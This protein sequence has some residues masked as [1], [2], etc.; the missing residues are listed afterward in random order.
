MTHVLLVAAM[1]LPVSSDAAEG[2]AAPGQARSG[3]VDSP[4]DLARSVPI[5]PGQGPIAILDQL[6]LLEDSESVLTIDQVRQR[7]FPDHWQKN[8]SD[9]PNFGFTGHTYWF[10]L[11]AHSTKPQIINQ[12]L[13]I[14]YP[15]LDH[16][17]LWTFPQG[18]H[19]VTGDASAFAN[20]PIA[21]RTFLFPFE[22]GPQGSEVFIRV[23]TEGAAKI[24]I[25]LWDERTFF[26]E[27]ESAMLKYGLFLGAIAFV[28][29]YNMLIFLWTRERW[30]LSYVIYIGCGGLLIASL[31]GLTFQFLWPNQP[32]WHAMSTA[33]LVPF[34]SVAALW[35]T[36]EFLDLKARGS[37][38]FSVTRVALIVGSLVTLLRFVLPYS[39]SLA[40]SIPGVLIPAIL[41]CVFFGAHL[42]KQGYVP[43]RYY[44]LSWIVFFTGGAAKGL[45]LFGVFPSFFLI[46]DGIQLGGAFQAL[47]LSYALAERFNQLKR[48]KQSIERKA[49]L[50]K[51]RASEELQQALE[52]AEEA[53][54]LK[55]EFLANI[56][57][58]LRTPLNAIIN[59]PKAMRSE[60]EPVA[61]W[62]CKACGG[63]FQDEKAP[64]I[65]ATAELH[66]DCP[67]CGASP[68]VYEEEWQCIGDPNEHVHF[69]K[70]IESSGSHLLAVVNDLLDIS[71]LEAG[72]MRVFFEPVSLK[73]LFAEIG[74]TIFP[75]AEAKEQ[76]V[77]F[78]PLSSDISLEADRIK[79][80]QILLNLLSN[81]VKF[82]PD[83]GKIGVSVD[84]VEFEAAEAIEFKISDTGIGIPQ[85]ALATIFEPFHQVDGTHTRSHEG[86]GLGLAISHR[87]VEMHGG[88][89]DVSSQIGQGSTFKL[90]LPRAGTP[91]R[92]AH[93]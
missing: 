37:W 47:L 1:L 93:A 41:L 57:H 18:S 6:Y 75:L 22:V 64:D 86:T 26:E 74:H 40:V 15:M 2:T 71:K 14:E 59:S 33:F 30:Y 50:A 76:Q 68:L 66:T 3:S 24:P 81:A 9:I 19:F 67:D 28:T 60:Y 84:I 82:T 79:L 85:S 25:R 80:A 17:E 16:I 62:S 34:V 42:W 51:V 56:S 20:R 43:A 38:Y 77:S 31:D 7:T 12:L 89:I 36:L 35:F 45:N 54:R 70:R 46:D 8:G 83:G 52:R 72:R 5:A 73:D 92:E 39:V 11:T 88:K 21:H 49:L 58:E 27:D 53:N 4:V 48:E 10:K 29:L 78:P 55:S 23:Q 91:Q 13:Q 87:L 65:Y 44:L 63:Q 90:L 32:G 61:L 69:L